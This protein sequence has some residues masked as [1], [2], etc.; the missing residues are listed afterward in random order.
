MATKTLEQ[1]FKATAAGLIV[2]FRRDWTVCALGIEVVHY[3]SRARCVHFVADQQL[4]FA[5]AGADELIGHVIDS[6][7]ARVLEHVEKGAQGV[8]Y[9][10]PKI[11]GID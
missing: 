2:Q 10:Q 3:E 11:S 6:L 1:I 5:R 7:S 4:Y 9:D 8:T